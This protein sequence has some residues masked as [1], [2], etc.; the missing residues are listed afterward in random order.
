MH[1]SKRDDAYEENENCLN[2]LEYRDGK[3]SQNIR[4]EICNLVMNF[5][6]EVI[7]Y[8]R[9]YEMMYTRYHY[10]QVNLE[11]HKHL[12]M[13][14]LQLIKTNTL[15][16]IESKNK[17][18]LWDVTHSNSTFAE[19]IQIQENLADQVRILIIEEQNLLERYNQCLVEFTK[20]CNIVNE[21][22]VL[23]MIVL[24]RNSKTKKDMK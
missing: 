12:Y 11:L 20:Y 5:G 21:T 22:F 7:K 23:L 14:L 6:N 24:N 13:R 1:N 4:R 10:I 9:L 17:H 19:W 18:I 16:K 15:P 8:Y 2:Y 3:N